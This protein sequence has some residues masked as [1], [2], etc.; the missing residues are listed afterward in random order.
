[1][2]SFAS[3]AV[4]V[5]VSVAALMGRPELP[6]EA[7]KTQSNVAQ[8][9]AEIESQERQELEALKNGKV[10][11]FAGPIADDAIFVDQHGVAGKADVMGHLNNL[12]LLEYAMAE[13]KFVAV[14]RESGVIAYKLTQK[15]REQGKD[16]ADTV[17]VSALWVKRSGKWVC[18]FT[19]ETPAQ[20][21]AP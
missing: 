20:A 16:F 11:E 13:I 21:P 15:G 4:A 12:K 1:M 8:L 3:F 19:Q 18:L 7:L 9:Q 2:R 10:Q 14:S 5:G 6:P 17:Y